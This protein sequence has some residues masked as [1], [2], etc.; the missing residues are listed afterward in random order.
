MV[1]TTVGMDPLTGTARL[2]FGQTGMMR[3]LQLVPVVVG[4]FGIGEILL[5]AEEGVQ[6]IYRGK[7]GK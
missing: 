3:G 4:L 5:A 1:L 6:N 7:L 2:H